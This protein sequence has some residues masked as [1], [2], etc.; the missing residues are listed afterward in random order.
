MQERTQSGGTV[1]SYLSYGGQNRSSPAARKDVPVAGAT[2]KALTWQAVQPVQRHA[3][4]SHN[5]VVK[6]RLSPCGLSPVA[7]KRYK[8]TVR[9][10]PQ[11]RRQ[12][13]D[14]IRYLAPKRDRGEPPGRAIDCGRKEKSPGLRGSRGPRPRG[15]D[16]GHRRGRRDKGSPRGGSRG[17]AQGKPR[18]GND[19]GTPNHNELVGV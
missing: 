7:G 13:Q 17:T 18:A 19:G 12:R 8:A 3:L 15:E 9:A 4:Q 11:D 5:G 2:W 14:V 6:L 16:T 1:A 10:A